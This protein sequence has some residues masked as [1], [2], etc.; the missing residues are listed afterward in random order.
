M[1]SRDTSSVDDDF[2]QEER[3][4]MLVDIAGAF[5]AM[6]DMTDMEMATFLNTFYAQCAKHISASG[7]EVLKYIGDAC[8]SIFA[9]DS[10]EQALKGAVALRG[11]FVDSRG[12]RSAADLSF[13]LHVG[14]V[15]LGEFGPLNHR[16][17]I[18]R[19]VNATFM[20]GSGPGIRLSERAYRR[21]PEKG[22]DAW[23]KVKPP[24]TYTVSW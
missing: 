11:E 7:G 18:S 12:Q 16:D 20:L 6:D 13:N 14:P 4:I 9:P 19:A 24:A 23:R 22:R 8:L 2:V 21:L 5:R 3:L 1:S 17:V 15:V 10:I